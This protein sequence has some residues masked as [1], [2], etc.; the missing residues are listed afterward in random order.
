MKIRIY[1]DTYD[2]LIRAKGKIMAVEG[3]KVEN[4]EV[5]KRALQILLEGRS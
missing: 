2:L 3:R 5:I 4:D 1:P